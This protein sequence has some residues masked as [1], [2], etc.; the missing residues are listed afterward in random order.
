MDTIYRKVFTCMIKRKRNYAE[1][2]NRIAK[3][4]L[5]FK[6]KELMKMWW[7]KKYKFKMNN[8]NI[9][10]GGNRR[11]VEDLNVTYHWK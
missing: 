11:Y 9:I 7:R 10:F 1:K 3:K 8:V 5:H 6:T 2:S 4:L